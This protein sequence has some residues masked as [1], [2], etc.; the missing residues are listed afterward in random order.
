MRPLVVVTTTFPFGP[1]ESF[2]APEIRALAKASEVVILPVTGHRDVVHPD[3][4][5]LLGLVPS[6]IARARWALRAAMNP[7][8]MASL[9]STMVDICRRSTPRQAARTV[10]ALPR[11]LAVAGAV[12]S[13][14][15]EHIHAYWATEPAAVAMAAASHSGVQWSFTAHRY[16]IVADEALSLKARSA[17]FTRFISRS[18]VALAE[19]SCRGWVPGPERVI[20]LGVDVPDRPGRPTDEPA[21]TIGCTARMIAVKDHQ[22]LLD[23]FAR[24][25]AATPLPIKLVLFGD[26]PLRGSIERRVSDL[27]LEHRVVL[28]GAL[29]HSDLLRHFAEGKVHIAVLA[30]QAGEG[31]AQE[32]IPVSLMEAMS[33]G[34]PAVATDS[35]GV[36]ELVADGGV[37]V[38]PGNAEALS[39]ALLRLVTD[40]RERRRIG[41]AGQAV[42]RA[43]FDNRQTSGDLLKLI[44]SAT[45][46]AIGKGRVLYLSCEE[47]RQGQASGKHVAAIA[48]GLAGRGWVVRLFTPHHGGSK[49]PWRRLLSI[50]AIQ[51]S[52]LASLRRHDILYVRAHPL[53]FPASLL[54]RWRGAR[55]VQEIN[56]SAE[57]LIDVWPVARRLAPM[58]RWTMAR[59]IA[60]SD[61]TIGVTSQLAA[62]AEDLGAGRTAVVPNGVDTQAFRPDLPR[63][64]IPLPGRFVIFV[65]TLAPWQGLPALLAAAALP[66]WPADVHL[67]VV[68]DG[69]LRQQVDEAVTRLPHVVA[70]GQIAPAEVPGVLAA[71]LAA[72]VPAGGG[73]R[74]DT[75]SGRYELGLSPL[76]LFEAMSC[77]IPVIAAD[78][79]ELADLVRKSGAG[80]IVPTGD[81]RALATAVSR[82]ARYPN[83]AKAMG[84][85]GRGEAVDHHDWSRR[86]AETERLLRELAAQPGLRRRRRNS[87]PRPRIPA[88]PQSGTDASADSRL[89]RSDVRLPRSLARE[90]GRRHMQAADEADAGNTPQ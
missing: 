14:G 70:L 73:R 30:S 20:H 67:V 15:A 69:P 71:A 13:L 6:A 81:S 33:Y 31:G 36:R 86:A 68:G 48:E 65:G 57:D 60:A 62:W 85:R 79:P 58:L 83:E 37:L 21:L 35:G 56:G 22:T 89:R 55:T 19:R 75:D 66:E 64:D 47:V 18:G 82:M 1:G 49:S 5:G 38:P 7:W 53:A 72:V 23:A 41:D 16:D 88:A 10:R 9:L 24:L 51:L 34:V 25:V 2:L 12:R 26:G 42:V 50:L 27:E 28:A 39:D 8:R 77:G 29:P 4:E 84:L 52:T 80:L 78:Q 17:A 45:A 44:A 54:A 43:S 46:L 11:A 90:V 63:P 3:Q 76:K 61:L 74:S 40:A 87:P 32:G 59:Q